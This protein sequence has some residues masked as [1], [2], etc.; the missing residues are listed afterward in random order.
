MKN[1]SDSKSKKATG[2]R[3]TA[4]KSR[5]MNSLSR[6]KSN[7]KVNSFKEFGS[8]RKLSKGLLTPPS[9]AGLHV[10]AATASICTTASGYC[11]C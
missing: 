5:P 3:K 4:K 10:A 7:Q 6:S 1:K 2:R 11:C 9:P 8:I